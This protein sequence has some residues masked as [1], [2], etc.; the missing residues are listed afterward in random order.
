MN[1]LI[2]AGI[3]VYAR[4]ALVRS[5]KSMTGDSISEN[6]PNQFQRQSLDLINNLLPLDSSGFYLVGADMQHRGVV[7]RNLSP[8]AERDYT[9]NFHELDPLRPSLFQRAST[10]V[11]CLDEL[12]SEAELLASDYY[13]HFMAP[14]NHRHV[15]DMFLRRDQDIIAVLT[16]LRQPVL[17]PFS[18]SELGMLRALQPFL[19]YTLNTVYL[20]RRYRE[21]AAIQALHQFTARELD[22][23]ELILAGASNKMIA[24][25]LNLSVATVKTHIQHVFQKVGVPSRTALSARLLG[26]L[27]L[28]E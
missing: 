6:F 24:T 22:V 17:G 21:R 14:L 4:R 20:P 10:R 19:E 5:A 2:W 11:A 9:R 26:D 16:M 27:R 7:L 3:P 25:E 13:R 1:A 23:V 28:R 18:D 12:Q 8:E 15:A